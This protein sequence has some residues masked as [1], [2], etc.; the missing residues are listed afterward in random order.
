[1]RFPKVL[2]VKQKFSSF[3]LPDVREAVR[4]EVRRVLPHTRIR[5]DNSVAV[6]VGS[7]GIAN[8]ATIVRGIVDELL[9]YGCRPF[10]VPCMGSHGGATAEGQR[11]V[12]EEYGI[13]QSSMGVPI[14]SAMD[15]GEVARTEEGL[16]VF[17]DKNALGADH[18]VVFNR[19]KP[20]TDFRGTIESGLM[21]MMT[22]GLGKH[23]G[24]QYYHRA[25][26]TYGGS[27]VI[28]AVGRAVLRNCPVAFGL[29]VVEDAYDNTALVEAILP[30]DIERR[31]AELLAQAREM[32][33]KL[34]FKKIDVLIIDRMGK[35]I[36][37]TGMDTNVIG[38]IHNIYEPEPEWP[39][40]TRIVVRDLTDETLGNATGVGLAD[41]VTK[42]LADKI[43]WHVTYT[44]CLTGLVVEKA[45]LPMVCPTD[46]DAVEAAL[47]TVGLVEPEQARLVWIRDT[48]SLHEVAVSVAFLPEI[49]DRDDLLVMSEPFDLPFDEVGNLRD[50]WHGYDPR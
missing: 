24:A 44:N 14:E 12:L 40:I 18:I 37:G 49:E 6:T 41:F 8:L 30:D 11:K 42:R 5:P 43:D 10:L 32:M 16:R 15:V 23:S 29:A 46:R 21:K 25:A 34:P 17:V 3:A 22:I 48:L 38:R 20:H 7:R 45:R 35:N 39:K 50:M 13:T 47:G 33:A 28:R 36:S 1:M 9:S 31:E 26:V 2:T 19:V 4:S 27:R